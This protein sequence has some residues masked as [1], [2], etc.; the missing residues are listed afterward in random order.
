MIAHRL[1]TVAKADEIC[2][3]DRGRIVERGQHGVLLA[4][5]R[6]YTHIAQTQF[7]QQDAG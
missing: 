4:L 1:S 5:G 6:T 7:P 3:I 2:V